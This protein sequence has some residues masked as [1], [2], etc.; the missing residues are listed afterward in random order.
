MHVVTEVQA[1]WSVSLSQGEHALI[2][3]S[4][5]V[6]GFALFAQF[7]RTWVSTNEVGARYR[8]AVIASLCVTGVAFLAYVYLVV[9]FDT[10]YVLRGTRY[11][12]TAEAINT[13]VPRYMDWSVTVPLLMVEL[14]A[15]SALRGARARSMR[16]VLMASAFLMIFTG[17]LGAAVIGGGTSESALLLWGLVSTAFYVALYVLLLGMLRSSK[18]QMGTAAYASYRNAMILLLSVWGVYPVAFAIHNWFPGSGWTTTLQ[19][20]FSAADITAKVGFGALIHKVAKLRTADDVVTGEQTHPEEVWI[21]SE[22]LSDGVQPVLKGLA[23]RVGGGV[24]GV[25]GAAGADGA[26]PGRHALAGTA[27]PADDGRT[28]P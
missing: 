16:F 20:A 13:Y 27:S 12:P 14:L 1:P 22:K 2:F 25:S 23:N 26:A 24:D 19:V 18:G 17:F 10:S 15:V 21:S 28:R 11:V 4:L 5:V 3:Y 7:V 8:T 6:A 9:K